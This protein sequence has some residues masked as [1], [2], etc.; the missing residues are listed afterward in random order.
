VDAAKCVAAHT[1]TTSEAAGIF[2]ALTGLEV[3]IS[4]AVVA[5]AARRNLTAGVNS[6]SD[7]AFANFVTK[8][9]EISRHS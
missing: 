6:I 4:A 1:G 5:V 2:A 3:A 8:Y 7:G 9:I